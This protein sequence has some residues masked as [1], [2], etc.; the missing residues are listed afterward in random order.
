MSTRPAARVTDPAAGTDPLSEASQNGPVI[1]A[2]RPAVRLPAGR[3]PA[4]D[5]GTRRAAK[6]ARNIPARPA[7]AGTVHAPAGSA[8]TCSRTRRSPGS[9]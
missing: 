2:F 9:A 7:M 5:L 6:E 8:W 4:I 1:L 3:W